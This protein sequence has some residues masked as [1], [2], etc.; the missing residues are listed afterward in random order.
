MGLTRRQF[1]TLLGGSTGAAV[2]FQACGVPP[3][4]LLVE[5]SYEMPEDMVSGLDNWYATVDA[6]SQVPN[7]LVVRVMEGR[8]KKI[9]GNIDY[10]VNKGKHSSSCE[11]SLQSLYHPDRIK[12][13]LLRVGSRGEGK[14]EEISWENAID[15]LSSELKKLKDSGQ[16]SKMAF[17][18]QPLSHHLNLMVNNFTTKFGGTH[19]TQEPLESTTLR[20]AINDVFGENKLPDFDIENSDYILSFGTDFLS[21]WVSPVQYSYDYGEFRQGKDKRGFLVQIDSRFSMTAANSDEWIY[22]QPGT[23]GMLALSIAQVIISEGLANTDVIDKLTSN[24]KNYL[25]NFAP[26]KIAS[27]ISDPS[28]NVEEVISK[29]TQIARDFANSSNPL[30]IGGGSAGAHTNGLSNLHNIYLLNHL[31]GSVNNKGGIIFNP[32]EPFF[33]KRPSTSAVKSSFNDWTKIVEELENGNLNVLLIHGADP[34]YGLPDSTG[35]KQALTGQ[36]NGNAN[37]SLIVSFATIMDDVSQMADLILP[38]HHFLE[39]WGISTPDPAPGHQLIGFQ[40]PVVRPYFENRGEHLGTKSFPNILLS[41]SKDPNLNLNLDFAGDTY[42]DIIKTEA[43]EIYKS[44]RGTVGLT[45]TSNFSNFES[46]WNTALQHGFWQDLNYTPKP[47]PNLP[48]FPFDIN[49]SDPS[50]SEINESQFYLIPFASNSL[51]DGISNSSLPW[52]QNLPDPISTAVWRTWVEINSKEA[53]NMNIKEGD[54]IKITSAHGSIEAIA[55]PNP[56]TP[57]QVISIPLGQ[58]HLSGGRFSEKRGA[59]VLSILAPFQTFGTGALAWAATRVK[60]INTGKW[61][62]LPKFENDVSEFPTDSE[63]HIIKITRYDT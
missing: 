62:R 11:A 22:V 46:F 5:S 25:D 29:I 42:L 24:N 40:Q 61:R 45:P 16:S 15:R 57:P 50:F 9:E 31:V 60:I 48:A 7:G 23:E 8:A 3:E 2:L 37:A 17:V 51:G 49:I 1:L 34:W 53:K 52:L 4:E 35:F 38:S 27:K 55:F 21:T 33:S 47:N 54:I 19:L 14:Y 36:N 26:S 20:K 6:K 56:A 13:P 32:E 39:D 43:K 30:A 44:G 58:G 63:Q 28:Q 41:I 10:P 18:T 59:N 12:A